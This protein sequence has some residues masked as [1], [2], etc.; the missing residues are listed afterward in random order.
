MTPLITHGEI[1]IR[2]YPTVTLFPVIGILNY[3]LFSGEV[4]VNL[5]ED[6]ERLR[7]SADGVSIPSKTIEVTF[8][9]NNGL[10]DLHLKRMDEQTANVP[11]FAANDR[12]EIMR[13]YIQDKSVS[14]V[15]SPLSVTHHN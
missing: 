12:G 8:P 2:T 10:V 4:T 5:K 15:L 14:N 3:S 13:Q 7:R 9:F 1:S 11:V 6:G